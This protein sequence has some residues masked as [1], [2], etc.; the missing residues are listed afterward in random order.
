[1]KGREIKKVKERKEKKYDSSD[2]RRPFSGF[3]NRES[4]PIYNL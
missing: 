1:M 2:R 4:L 3:A